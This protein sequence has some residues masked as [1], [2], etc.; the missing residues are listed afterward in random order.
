MA[1]KR[2]PCIIGGLCQRLQYLRENYMIHMKIGMFIAIL[3]HIFEALYAIKLATQLDLTQ[4]TIQKWAVQT[5][6]MGY[7][8]L[9]DL[10]KY[11]DEKVVQKQKRK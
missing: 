10:I 11:H 6:M 3:L 1:T 9:Q 7:T 2:R 5:G 8:S 4:E